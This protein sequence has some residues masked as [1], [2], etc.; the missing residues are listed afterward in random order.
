MPLEVH[1]RGKVWH[2]RGRVEYNGRP[3]TDYIR[4]STGSST[5]AG[6]WQWVRD[7]EA[8]EIRRYLLGEE[9]ALTFA[10]AVMLYRASPQDAEYLIE[11]VEEIGSLPLPEITPKML[12][13]L[14]R[15]LR[16][17]ASSDTWWRLFVTPARAVIN[18]AHEEGAGTPPIRV[19]AYTEQ[20]RIKQDLARGKPSRQKRRP[21]TR[22]W[23]DLFCAYADIYNA[24]MARFLF[25]TAARIDQAVSLTPDDLDLPNC[26]VWLKAQKGH[27]ALWVTISHEMMVELANLPLKRPVDRKK[28]KRLPE[29][30]FGYASRGGYRKRWKTI[31]KEAG[32]PYLTAHSGRHGFYTEL[33]VRQG[34]D[35]ITA[36]KAGRWKDA[37]LPDSIY[38][39]AETDEA[40]IRAIFRT[41]PAQHGKSKRSNRL[42]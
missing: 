30:V 19:R 13:G 35:P 37:K 29:R 10:D 34:V 20:E 24:A 14:G 4:E 28:G 16:P 41:K 5:E 26:R 39:H 33:R 27:E 40:E 6:A 25:E 31:C 3:I 21:F 22:E 7:R 12:K 23:L 15:K 17:Q 8:R 11:V 9:A 1:R 18:N 32:I 2:A 38:A 36:A 42:K